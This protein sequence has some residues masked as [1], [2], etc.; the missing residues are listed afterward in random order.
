MSLIT[1]PGA[2]SGIPIEQYH[3]EEIC[4]SPSLSPTG[5]K[6]LCGRGGKGQTP[7]HFWEQSNLNPNRREREQT[8]A[9]RFGA[10][11]HDALLLPERWKGRDHYHVT[12]EGFSRATRPRC[13][14]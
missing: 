4:P 5:A 13:W 3:G 7:R 11:L 9:L 2:Y 1:K 14:A 12:C 6:P 10:A 8:D